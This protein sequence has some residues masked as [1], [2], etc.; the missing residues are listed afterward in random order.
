MRVYEELFI[1]KPDTAE[2]EADGFVEQ[3]KDVIT[4]GKGTVDKVDKWGVRKLAY[5]VSKYDEGLYILIQFTASPDAVKEVERRMRVTD[6]VI[7]FITVRIDEKQKKIE[8]RKKAREKRAARRPAPQA[9]APAA[10][11]RSRA[12][13]GHAAPGAHAPNIRLRPRRSTPGHTAA[14]TVAAQ[15]DEGRRRKRSWQKPRAED[16]SAA[17]SVPPAATKRLPARNNIS[18]ARKCAGSAST[19]STISTTKKCGCSRRSSPNAGRSRRGAFPACARR[20][21]GGWPRRSSRR[22]ISR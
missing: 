21:S 12:N 20:T 15:K 5:R 2:E 9:A 13:G 14:E 1:L 18:G 16:Q 6:M 8:K 11:R 10:P 4:N 3:L 22:A 17:R 19:R 7:K